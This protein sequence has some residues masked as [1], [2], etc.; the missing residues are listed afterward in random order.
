MG[1]SGSLETTK[2]A[3]RSFMT[4]VRC[5]LSSRGRL[6]DSGPD[7]IHASGANRDKDGRIR[8][9]ADLRFADKNLPHDKRWNA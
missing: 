1:G 8:L 2:P 7:M 3:T 9:S 5:P 4:A 6:A